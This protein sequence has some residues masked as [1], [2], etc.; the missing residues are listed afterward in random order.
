MQ[1]ANSPNLPR[2]GGRQTFQWLPFFNNAKPSNYV[3]AL[4]LIFIPILLILAQNETG[5]HWTFMAL[6]LMLYREGMSGLI[7]FAAFPGGRYFRCG[8]E[9]SI[10]W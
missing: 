8:R 6:F 10:P 2:P 7:L 1:P 3:K 4:C 9:Y 5:R